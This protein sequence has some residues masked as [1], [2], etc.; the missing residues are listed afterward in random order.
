MW[1]PSKVIEWFTDMRDVA[2]TNATVSMEAVNHYR[3]ELVAVRAE[4]D[5]LKE[6]LAK[7]LIMGD[8][9][10]MQVNSLQLERTALMEKA[11]NI[12]IPA[13][14]LIRTPVINEEVQQFSFSDMGDELAKKYGFP[15]YEPKFTN[16][17]EN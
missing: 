5:T 9:L 4:R 3:E 7:T 16:S 15:T 13:P 14:E 8:W 10:R 6:Q 11:Y 17:P 1:V 2:E 12:K